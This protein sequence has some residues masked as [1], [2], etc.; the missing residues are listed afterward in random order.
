MISMVSVYPKSTVFRKYQRNFNVI[1]RTQTYTVADLMRVRSKCICLILFLVLI[2]V[3]AKAQEKERNWRLN[4]HLQMLQ[5][6][7]MPAETKQWQTMTMLG[8]RLDFRWNPGN[9]YSFHAGFRNNLNLGQMVQMYYPYYALM[10]TTEQG[11]FDLT[12]P[13]VNDSSYYFYSNTT[14]LN[15]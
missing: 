2:S 15:V 8:N 5:E 14:R 9:T 4:G 7:W 11:F 3:S 12:R 1:D 6:V 13:W 10:S